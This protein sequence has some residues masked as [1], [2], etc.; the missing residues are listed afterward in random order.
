MFALRRYYDS[1]RFVYF[2]SFEWV[3]EVN[4][5][6]WVLLIVVVVVVQGK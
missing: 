3:D 5:Y 2:Q 6:I 1:Q 4:D